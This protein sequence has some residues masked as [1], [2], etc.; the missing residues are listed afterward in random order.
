MPVSRLLPSGIVRTP[1]DRQGDNGA[2]LSINSTI[3]GGEISSM[4]SATDISERELGETVAGANTGNEYFFLHTPQGYRNYFTLDSS[5]NI[6]AYVGLDGENHTQESIVSLASGEELL[7][8]TSIGNTVLL[9]TSESI[10]YVLW[11]DGEYHY[12]GTHIPEPKVAFSTISDVSQFQTVVNVWTSDAD[13]NPGDIIGLDLQ[14]WNQIIDGSFNPSDTDYEKYK[15]EYGEIYLAIWDGING[16]IS[17]RRALG[18]FSTPIIA[19]Y[20]LRL[21]DGS[22]IY[23]SVPIVLGAGFDSFI[24]RTY[25]SRSNDITKANVEFS[26]SYKVKAKLLDWDEGNWS[27]IIEGI[28]IFLSPDVCNPILGAE[29]IKAQGDSSTLDLT[30]DGQSEMVNL[31]HEGDVSKKSME[32]ILTSTSTFYLVKEIDLEEMESGSPIVTGMEIEPESNDIL[33]VQQ[34]LNDDALSH[35]QYASLKGFNTYNKRAM[36]IGAKTLLYPGYPFVQ[37]TGLYY[38]TTPWGGDPGE[39]YTHVGELDL[40]GIFYYIFYI[41]DTYGQTYTVKTSAYNPYSLGSDFGYEFV[42]SYWGTF[43]PYVYGFVCYPDPKCYKAEFYRVNMNQQTEALVYSFEMKEHPSLNC[44]YGFVGLNT[45]ILLEQ[46]ETVTHDDYI[47]AIDNSKA[48]V[49]KDNVLMQSEV[50]NPFLFPTSGI[51]EFSAS[52]IDTA[53]ITRP[54]SEGQFGEFPVYVFTQDGLWA[55]GL[56][57][58]GTFASQKPV[59]RDIAYEGTICATEQEISFSSAQGVMLLTGSDIKCISLVLEGKGYSL[60]NSVQSLLV[61][62]AWEDLRNI[63]DIDKPISAFIKAS[64]IIYDYV[65]RRLILASPAFDYQYVYELET[66]SWHMMYNDLMAGY[67]RPI[68]SYPEALVTV[69]DDNLYKIVELS[70]VKDISSTSQSP[71]MIVSDILELDAEDIRKTVEQIKIRGEYDKTHA[72]YILLASQDRV[73]FNVVSSLRGLSAK[74]FRFILLLNIIPSEIISYIDF[75]TSTRWTN[76]LR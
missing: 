72:K 8:A 12:L 11:K 50:M 15:S 25:L 51:I 33:L 22:Y 45:N 71:V 68:N 40:Y 59:S 14:T 63:T 55:L 1:S 57:N 13:A 2:S 54:L 16:E 58:D 5:G 39:T 35:H 52:V 43:C 74:Y 26:R 37:T 32:K 75:R 41:R 6:R 49:V 17:H 3:T 60:D 76:K 27:D 46:A 21:Y 56:N 28:S 47:N 20:A 9:S 24:K 30:L 65:N 23:Q 48:V 4:P 61:D 19:R 62:T 18:Y 38:D 67:V 69:I 31:Y 53:V 34:T 42:D 36:M 44:A 70:R 73:H 64:K 7:N 66:G 10:H 29:I